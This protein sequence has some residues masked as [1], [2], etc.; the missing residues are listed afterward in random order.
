MSNSGIM[1]NSKPAYIFLNGVSCGLGI[2]DAV[3]HDGTLGVFPAHRQSSG[4]GVVHTHVP[5]ATAGHWVRRK[6]VFEPS[7]QNIS[8][9]TRCVCVMDKNW[10]S[11]YYWNTYVLC[12]AQIQYKVLRLFFLLKDGL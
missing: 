4:G 12:C 11:T 6:K 2:G 8:V 10:L 1:M 9:S 5:R 7:N 3:L